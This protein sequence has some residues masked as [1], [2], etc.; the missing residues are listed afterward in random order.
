[1]N[2]FRPSDP[3]FESRIRGSFDKQAVMKDCAA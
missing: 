2:R 3:D 1:M